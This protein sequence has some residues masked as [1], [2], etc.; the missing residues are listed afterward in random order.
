MKLTAI[1]EAGFEFGVMLFTPPFACLGGCN[2]RKKAKKK[3]HNQLCSSF[4]KDM[5]TSVKHQN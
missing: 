1:M 4:E 5:E 2:T 3:N